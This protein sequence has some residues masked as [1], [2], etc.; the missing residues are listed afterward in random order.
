MKIIKCAFLITSLI[1]LFAGCNHGDR[2]IGKW[3]RFGD[4]Y[5]GLQINVIKEGE[6]FKA[7]IIQVTDSSRLDGF[8]IGDVKWK[9]IKQTQENKYELEDL[10]K[11]PV[12]FSDKFESSYDLTYLELVNQNELKTRGFSKGLEFVGTEQSW[13]RIMNE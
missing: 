1:L 8:V 3:Q 12:L 11:S 13:T 4:R 7:V 9:N 2:L 6:S 5:K 10:S